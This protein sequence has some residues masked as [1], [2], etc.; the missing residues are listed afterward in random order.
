MSD[1]TDDLG[2]ALKTL[3]VEQLKTV[4]LLLPLVGTLLAI[5]FDVGYFTGIDI[6]YFSV[7][8][9]AEHI[10]F[11]LQVAPLALIAALVSAMTI[12]FISKGGTKEFK[13][14]THKTIVNPIT[15]I[16][17]VG[18]LISGMALWLMTGLVTVIVATLSP[19]SVI[20]MAILH[21]RATETFA[22]SFVALWCYALI[23]SLGYDSGRLD[24]AGNMPTHIL[25]DGAEGRLIKTGER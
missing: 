12:S 20:V 24:V 23:F 13:A 7:F 16:A 9:L 15:L 4:V 25:N 19:I 3:G 11:A 17:C 14:K 22:L 2:D 5:T 8:S 1:K 10:G 21:P 18:L 6:K